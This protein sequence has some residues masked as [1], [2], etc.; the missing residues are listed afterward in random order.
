MRLGIWPDLRLRTKGLIVIA[1]PAAATVLIACASYILGTRATNAEQALVRNLQAGQQIQLLKTSMAESRSQLREYFLTGQEASEN[2]IRDAVAAFDNALTKLSSLTDR[3]PWAARQLTEIAALERW[4]VEYFFGA[5]AQFRS[6]ALPPAALQAE[7]QAMDAKRA[8]MEKLMQAMKTH[9]ERSLETQLGDVDRLHTELRITTGIFA[10]FGVLGGVLV[11]LLFA[12]G[13]THRVAM[14]QA[15]VSHLATG[16]DLKTLPG[17][18]DEIGALSDSVARAADVL[19]QKTAALENALHGIARVDQS[20]CYLSFNQAYAEIANLSDAEA[21]GNFLDTLRTEDR[22]QVETAVQHMRSTGSAE[23]E[24]RLA[25]SS[26]AIIDVAMTFLPVSGDSN[27]D[28]YVFARDITPRKKTEAD[29]VRAKDAA[30]AASL[31]KNDFLAKISHDIRTPLNAILG[32]ANLLSETPLSA[33]QQEYV[34]LFRRNSTRLVTLIND[35]LD[36]SRIEA[37]ALRLEKV[38][39]QIRGTVE[40][41]VGTFRD[42]AATKGVDSEVEIAGD[43]PGYA[44]GDPARVQQILVNLVSNALKFTEHGGVALTVR[45][46]T[47]SAGEVLSF[48]VADTGPGILAERPR[49]SLCAVYAI[50]PATSSGVRGSGLGLTICRELVERMGGEIGVSSQPGQGSMFYFSFPLEAAQALR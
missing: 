28:Y 13:I 32:G 44:L 7:L 26:G 6:G 5:M 22:T 38:P 25:A 12:S 1:F 31:A 20:G 41:A 29:L 34:N 47:G 36:F 18:R 2:Q 15:S 16:G 48:E 43:V 24:I 39:F 27:A 11:S 40:D 3:D 8:Q 17:G 19:R 21:R 50:D 9:Q 4:R 37:G 23:L 30:L 35:F 49:A 46:K 14:L 45:R 33:D 42:W 10:I